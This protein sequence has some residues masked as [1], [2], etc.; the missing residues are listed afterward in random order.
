MEDTL[1]NKK[2]ELTELLGRARSDMTMAL[3][4]LENAVKQ[5][6]EEEDRLNE[7]GGDWE[8]DVL[9]V[10]NFISGLEEVI[11]DL[12]HDIPVIYSLLEEL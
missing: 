12:K 2:L 9:K 7:L 11:C 6:E 4:Y 3:A 5:T 10:K 1:V 8:G